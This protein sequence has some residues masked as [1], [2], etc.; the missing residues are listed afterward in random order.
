MTAKRIFPA[1][2]GAA[3]LTV[4]LAL[5]LSPAPA[6][7]QQAALTPLQVEQQIAPAVVLIETPFA[8]GSGVLTGPREILTNAHVVLPF[9]TVTVTFLDGTT[10]TDVPIVSWDLM[11]DVAMLTLPSDAP[12]AP[13]PIVDAL[14]LPNGTEVY[15]IGYPGQPDG[16]TPLR[17]LSGQIDGIPIWAALGLHYVR[18]DIPVSGGMSGGAVVTTAGDL[19]GFNEWSL[20]GTRSV[21]P[22]V[23]NV[24]D[25]FEAAAAGEDVDRLG[26]RYPE[27]TLPTGTSFNFTLVDERDEGVFIVP[28]EATGNLTIRLTSSQPVWLGIVRPGGSVVDSREADA[29]S[30]LT[31]SLTLPGDGLPLYVIVDQLGGPAGNYTLTAS[32]TLE[33]FSDPDDRRMID[34]NQLI[35]GQIDYPLDW[36]TYLVPLTEG[37]RLGVTVDSLL[38][39]M[40]AAVESFDGEIT[41]LAFDDDSGGGVWGL[42]PLLSFTA[43]ADG[44]YLLVIGGVFDDEVGGYIG[45]VLILDPV[46]SNNGTFSAPLSPGGIAL[47]AWGGGSIEQVLSGATAAGCTLQSFWVT[48]NGVLVGYLAGAPVFVNSAFVALYPQNVP[49]NTPMLV[50]CD[51]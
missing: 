30:D 3:V 34:Q 31:I 23:V 51:N 11:G 13:L 40:F 32:A 4:T 1:T 33:Q 25:R 22:S 39:D 24:L 8:T 47:A 50:S 26:Q 17:V 12:V 18:T 5:L 45:N 14:T 16:S 20:S 29:A 48:Q 10:F 19:I 36:D 41:Q 2:L 46:G 15:S 42:D 49:Q 38:V 43:P 21:G 28:P 37:Q 9:S 7:G 44:E 27:V 35:W 6:A